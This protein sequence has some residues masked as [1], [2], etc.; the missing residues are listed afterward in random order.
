[1]PDSLAD[2]SLSVLLGRFASRTPTPGGGAA[3]PLVGALA[4][5]L[6]HMV[7]NYSIG[8]KSLADHEADLT[9][10]AG[11][12]ERARSTLL[13]L[14]EAD[15]EAY[16]SLNDAFKM[17]KDDPARA[18]RIRSA[19]AA[20]II[21][22]RA[23]MA[24]CIDLLRMLERLATMTN[25]QLASDLRI[26]AVLAEAAVRASA[27]NVRVNLPMLGDGKEPEALA[28]ECERSVAEAQERSGRV[29]QST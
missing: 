28:G 12:L 15:A 8:K 13:E 4:S 7:V 3:A 11:R 6:A 25:R 24:T 19:A 20:A 26:A 16:A 2:V 18:E 29:R 14:A 27:E 1:M 9:D 21:P 17:A 23:T 5:A 22:P 10:A